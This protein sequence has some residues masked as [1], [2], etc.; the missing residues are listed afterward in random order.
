VSQL[1]YHELVLRLD[2]GPLRWIFSGRRD[3]LSS[4]CIKCRLTLQT[5]IVYMTLEAEIRPIG[6]STRHLMEA[7]SEEPWV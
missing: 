4:V 3:G 1:A 7:K 5:W 6:L 2:E